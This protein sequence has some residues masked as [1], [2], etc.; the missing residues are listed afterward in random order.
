MSTK[1]Y[2]ST[3]DAN[4]P[5]QDSFLDVVTNIVGILIILMVVAGLRVKNA[6]RQAA[7]EEAIRT[8]AA[9]LD[10]DLGVENSLRQDV[11]KTAE[12][13]RALH[14]EGQT[15]F[16]ERSRLAT[17]VSTVERKIKSARDELDSGSQH[18][19]D[20]QRKL[21]DAQRDLEQIEQQQPVVES[22]AEP[23]LVESYPTPIGKTVDDNEVHFQL[24]GGRI[25]YVPL[26]RLIE[27]FRTDAQQKAYRLM[28]LPE[29]TDTVGP[30]GG[31]RL[32]YT[33]E[34]HDVPVETQMATGRGA[35]ARLKRWTLIPVSSEL[36]EPVE[37]ALADGSQFRQALS[38]QR[39]DKVTVTIWTYPDSFDKFRQVKKELFR[40]GFATAARPLPEGTPIGGSP[41]GSKSAAE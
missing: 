6:P 28:D 30:E 34:R 37:A 7:E 40:S 9:S 15:R 32:R 38:Q 16:Q 23:I 12:Q 39:P 13:I 10:H 36:G 3:S 20:L 33:M 19:F 24:R 2:Q 35:Y 41:E 22:K 27:R 8:T 14:R 26:D 18:S 5:G 11:L 4:A 29:L 31:F 1:R 17:L 25:A 21:S